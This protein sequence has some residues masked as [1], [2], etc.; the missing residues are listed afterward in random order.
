M[1]RYAASCLEDVS[2]NIAAQV[3]VEISGSWKWY[4]CRSA[5]VIVDALTRFE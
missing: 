2:S 3:S 1:N 4:S 5:F